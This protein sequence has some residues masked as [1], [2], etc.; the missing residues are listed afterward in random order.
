MIEEQS[1]GAVIFRENANEIFFLL[2]NYPSEHWDFVKGKIE[3]NESPEKTTIRETKEETGISDLEF[4]NGFEEKIEYNFQYDNNLIHKQVVFFLAQTKTKNVNLSHEHLD[5]I[6]L[7]YEN[8][9]KKI[10]YENSRNVLIKAYKLL[11]QA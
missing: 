10:T 2:L 11:L 4:V 9:V 1:A 5:Y 3:K 7:D 8:A 6:W